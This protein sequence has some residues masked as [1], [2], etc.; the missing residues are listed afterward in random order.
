M[1]VDKTPCVAR[2]VCKKNKI[3]DIIAP[4]SC[5]LDYIFVFLRFLFCI[6]GSE[7]NLQEKLVFGLQAQPPKLVLC[8]CSNLGFKKCGN[9]D[10]DNKIGILFL[11]FRLKG[12]RLD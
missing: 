5:Q 2:S 9:Y 3:E 6:L 8:V 1:E 11:V 10:E 7:D 4:K 12:A